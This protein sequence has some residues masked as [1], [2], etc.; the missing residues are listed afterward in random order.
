MEKGMSFFGGWWQVKALVIC[1]TVLLIVAWAILWMAA[2][3]EWA[4]IVEI[5]R[6]HAE[7]EA[8]PTEF[9]TNEHRQ[10]V[11]RLKS[12]QLEPWLKAHAANKIVALAK[13]GL[14]S[15]TIVY[16]EALED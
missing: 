10:S 2:V 1:V 15:F 5:D 16:E 12:G 4:S 9:Y 13:N 8:P 6:A 11:V 7:A 3:N 14:G